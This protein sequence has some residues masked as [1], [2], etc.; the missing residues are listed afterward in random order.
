MRFL[1]KLGLPLCALPLLMGAS[2]YRWVDANGVV[3]YTQLKPEGVE[4][5]LVSA[6]TGQRASV[7][8]TRSVP[9]ATPVQTGLN[10][11]QE[12]MLSDLKAVEA[13]RQQEI[14]DI[15]AAN[16]DEARDVLN[17]LTSRGR[18]RVRGDD[19]EERVMPEDERQNRIDESQR[20]VAVNCTSS[21]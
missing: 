7:R 11:K 14:A 1:F 6:D 5:E 8:P 4:A 12:A 10:A 20:A 2:V 19:G 21:G 17:R 9:T 16:C 15:R 18:I 13:E 3:N